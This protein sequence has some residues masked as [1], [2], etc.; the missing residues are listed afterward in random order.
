MDDLWVLLYD[1]D[2]GQ[3]W[4]EMVHS[5]RIEAMFLALWLEKAAGGAPR[6]HSAVVQGWAPIPTLDQVQRSQYA[7]YTDWRP[8]PPNWVGAASTSIVPA[9]NDGPI[10]EAFVQ[11]WVETAQAVRPRMEAMRDRV[12]QC[13]LTQ[14]SPEFIRMMIACT[15]QTIAEFYAEA[16][17][18]AVPAMNHLLDCMDV[19]L[20][21]HGCDPVRKEWN[22]WLLGGLAAGGVVLIGGG[23]ILATRD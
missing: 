22:P 9:S 10:D 8:R 5:H 17:A 20:T 16:L 13:G 21:K 12:R 6:Y 7:V 1:A 14:D 19:A 15:N 3:V 18:D 2:T 4:G 11:Q 23:I